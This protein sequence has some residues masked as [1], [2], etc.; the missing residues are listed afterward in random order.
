[1]I[2][3]N[4]QSKHKTITK[5]IPHDTLRPR[6]SVYRS[7]QHIYAQI[8]DDKESKTLVAESDLKM[9]KGTKTEKANMVGE[10]LAKKALA[11][12]ITKVT[13]DRGGFLYHGRIKQLAEGARKGGLEF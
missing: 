7:T 1:M 13:F 8:I 12:K 9:E 5:R 4:R 3:K 10:N 2:K 6:L 11:L